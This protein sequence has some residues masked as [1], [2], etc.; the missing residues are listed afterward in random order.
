MRSFW[1]R[2][3]RALG[4]DAEHPGDG[5]SPEVGRGRKRMST[6]QV[7]VF[8]P[9]GFP[10]AGGIAEKLL[11]GRPVI[12]NL[13]GVALEQAQR[14]IDYISGTTYYL[15]GDLEKVGEYIFLFTP[16]G[17][18][19]DAEQLLSDHKDWESPLL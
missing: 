19:I 2:L 9:L 16:E 6:E 14:V 13:E 5:G 7:A 4:R 3:M 1:Q 10:D 17:V 11:S 15:G 8:Y 12:V 18:D